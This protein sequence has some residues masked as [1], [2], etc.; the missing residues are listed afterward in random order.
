MM[1]YADVCAP[2]QA[3][4]WRA[5]AELERKLKSGATLPPKGQGPPQVMLGPKP[6]AWGVVLPAKKA[7]A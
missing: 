4:K 3:K 1:C 7:Q 5:R 6:P 2:L